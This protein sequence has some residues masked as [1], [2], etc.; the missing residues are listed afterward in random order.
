MVYLYTRQ[1]NHG[2]RNST[3]R[4]TNSLQ[5]PAILEQ[6]ASLAKPGNKPIC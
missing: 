4:Y 6:H 2:A 3:A 1:N 5:A